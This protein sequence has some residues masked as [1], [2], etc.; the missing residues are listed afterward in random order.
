MLI[1]PYQQFMHFPKCNTKQDAFSYMYIYIYIKVMTQQFF[2]QE[3]IVSIGISKSMSNPKTTF[4][5]HGY[6]SKIPIKKLLPLVVQSKFTSTGHRIQPIKSLGPSPRI[7]K[8]RNIRIKPI[9]NKV[10]CKVYHH[11]CLQNRKG[12]PK[13]NQR[14]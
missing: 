6:F 7:L 12:S 13:S 5:Q 10:Y 4:M 1:F 8:P 11:I 2:F 3:N 9:N 14:H